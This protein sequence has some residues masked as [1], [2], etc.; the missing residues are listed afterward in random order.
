MWYEVWGGC[1]NNNCLAQGYTPFKQFRRLIVEVQS[2][3]RGMVDDMVE[4]WSRRRALQQKCKTKGKIKV[5]LFK[6]FLKLSIYSM[7]Y[8]ALFYNLSALVNI[9]QQALSGKNRVYG[10]SFS[11]PAANLTWRVICNVWQLVDH[12]RHPGVAMLETLTRFR[13]S[14]TETLL[15][16]SPVGCETESARWKSSEIFIIIT[17]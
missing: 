5:I 3:V 12:T 8:T 15:L 14:H 9:R 13:Y 17:P 16:T 2:L 4:V 10:E 11:R 6:L 7:R 1:I